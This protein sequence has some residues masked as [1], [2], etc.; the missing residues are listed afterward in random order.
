[1][2]GTAYV[3]L[4]SSGKTKVRIFIFWTRIG[5]GIRKKGNRHKTKKQHYCG[6]K[7]NVIIYTRT[8]IR[9]GTKT[10]KQG[11]DQEQQL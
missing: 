11:Q 5:T 2:E 9:T 3:Y 4:L 1:M 7:R 6:G 8:R 10:R